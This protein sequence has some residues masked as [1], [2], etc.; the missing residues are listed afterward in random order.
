V[1]SID[2]QR[3]QAGKLNIG[4][5][6]GLCGK[7]QKPTSPDV[8]NLMPLL[9]VKHIRGVWLRRIGLR[10]FGLGGNGLMRLRLAGLALAPDLSPGVLE[11][12][13]TTSTRLRLDTTLSHGSRDP[14][15]Y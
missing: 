12:H 11:L 15:E 9:H 8:L 7:G 10:R 5:G 2:I 3:P 6:I 4:G 14:P 1:I 13:K